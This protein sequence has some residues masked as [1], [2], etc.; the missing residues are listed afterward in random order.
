VAGEVAPAAESAPLDLCCDGTLVG[1]FELAG[2]SEFRFGG[3]PPGRK[4]IELWLPQFGTFRLRALALSAG[5]TLAPCEDARRRWITYGSS[6][7]Q[8]RAATSPTRT[9][10]AIV[11]RQHGLNL[12]CL[13]FGGQCHLDQ[14]IARLIRDLRAEYLSMCVGINIYGA[15]SLSA[16]TLGPAIIAFVQT[17]RERHPDTPFAVLSPIHSPLREATPN[18]VG[19]TLRDVRAEVAAA[20]DA[21]RAAGDRHVAYVDGLTIFGPE[22]AHLLPDELHPDADGYR[23]MGERFLR[24]VAT[25]RFV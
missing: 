17:I 4:L 16:R 25:P 14:M 22:H 3:L 6:I 18:A 15:A 13:G 23:V 8:C 21:L 1:S 2:K 10:P 24:L 11:A 7:T 5:A 19:L 12:T 20:V 9:W